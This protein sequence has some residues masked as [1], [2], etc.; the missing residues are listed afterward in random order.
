MP[1]CRTEPITRQGPARLCGVEVCNSNFWCHSVRRQVLHWPNRR[2]HLGHNL[3]KEDPGADFEQAEQE[4]AHA[5]LY[6]WPRECRYSK[7]QPRIFSDLCGFG[8]LREQPFCCWDA[9]WSNRCCPRRRESSSLSK[10]SNDVFDTN[11]TERAI[12]YAH[13]LR[14]HNLQFPSQ[15]LL[16]SP[17]NSYVFAPK[18]YSK[19]GSAKLRSIAKKIYHNMLADLQ[20]VL[21]VIPLTRRA[22]SKLSVAMHA[23][24]SY[25]LTAKLLYLA[26]FHFSC[27]AT[28]FAAVIL[29]FRGLHN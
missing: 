26:F 15:F 3:F 13:M 8:D 4:D 29:W 6:P 28:D 7:C 11:E 27:R 12:C 22:G 20:C 2:T 21:P 17:L 16:I 9:W 5:R 24:K 25:T 19:T 18:N 1:D 10:A 23:A 14:W